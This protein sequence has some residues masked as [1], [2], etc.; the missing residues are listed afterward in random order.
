MNFLAN[1]IFNS[2]GKL[3]RWQ[4]K[5]VTKFKKRSVERHQVPASISSSPVN[6]GSASRQGGGDYLVICQ[7]CKLLQVESSYP[8]TR[9]P[10]KKGISTD[11]I[12]TTLLYCT[13][14]HVTSLRVFLG[15]FLFQICAPG[16][17][18][19]PETGAKELRK[20][21]NVTEQPSR[22]PPYHVF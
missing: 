10:E 15:T 9:V 21:K 13:E 22:T 12:F 7:L 5:H 19:I 4:Q 2:L 11:H 3:S 14:K 8:R 20:G 16:D 18:Q 17:Q 1:P 6:H